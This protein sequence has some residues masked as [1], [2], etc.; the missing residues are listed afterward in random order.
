M[1]RDE[2]GNDRTVSRATKSIHV[3]RD[4]LCAGELKMRKNGIVDKYYAI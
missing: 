3:L 2:P 4:L 1:A